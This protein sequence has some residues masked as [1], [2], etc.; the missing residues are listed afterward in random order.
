MFTPTSRDVSWCVTVNPPKR[1]FWVF[2][3]IFVSLTCFGPWGWRMWHRSVRQTADSMSQTE[4]TRYVFTLYDPDHADPQGES[5][6]NM[7]TD[8]MCGNFKVVKETKYIS[9]STVMNISSQ[10]PL[11]FAPTLIKQALSVTLTHIFSEN[12][13]SSFSPNSGSTCVRTQIFIVWTSLRSC[14]QG[15]CGWSFVE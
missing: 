1:H 2:W 6:S 4:H 12:V 13:T 7:L 11:V 15:V 14:P 3:D 8:C 9:P 5:S 10:P